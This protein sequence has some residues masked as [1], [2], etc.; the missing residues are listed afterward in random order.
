MGYRVKR[1]QALE[2]ENRKLNDEKEYWHLE[3]LKWASK[4]GENKMKI[5]KLLNQFGIPED[6]F[7]DDELQKFIEGK[8]QQAEDLSMPSKASY[9]NT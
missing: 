2:D 1:I 6:N 4:L 5:R 9:E 8:W 7:K 3:A